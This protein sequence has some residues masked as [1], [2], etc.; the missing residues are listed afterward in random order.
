MSQFIVLKGNFSVFFELKPY[1]LC[2]KK[3]HR[4]D[5][6]VNINQIR[7]VILETKSQFF[8]KLCITLQRHERYLF[9]FLLAEILYDLDKRSPSKCKI[10]D[11]RLFTWNVT[12]IGSFCRKRIKFQPK[13]HRWVV[14]HDIEEW[15]KIWRKTYLLFQKWQ[16]F[17]SLE[18]LHFDWSLLCKVFNVWPKNVQRSYLSWRWRVMQNLKKN[19]LVAFQKTDIPKNQWIKRR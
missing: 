3:A 17:S 19:W 16:E 9:C 13:K 11:F 12:L 5:F 4:S 14:S 1:I 7:H 2:S 10:S 8:L 15:C 6:W 18:N